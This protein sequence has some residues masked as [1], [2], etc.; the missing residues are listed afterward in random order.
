VLDIRKKPKNTAIYTLSSFINQRR[1]K[2]RGAWQVGAIIQD[3]TFTGEKDKG[4]M[5][6]KILTEMK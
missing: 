3:H 5:V 4:G 2:L 6:G 1:L